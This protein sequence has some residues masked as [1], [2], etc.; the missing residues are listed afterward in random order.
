MVLCFGWE[1]TETYKVNI[2]I[3]LRINRG[4]YMYMASVNW[5]TIALDI[6]KIFRPMFISPLHYTL[7]FF[8]PPF[9]SASLLLSSSS[10]QPL[11]LPPLLFGATIDKSTQLPQLHWLACS[12]PSLNHRCCT[13]PLHYPPCSTPTLAP[14]LP[15]LLHH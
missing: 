13:V 9:S 7:S 3:K 6:F 2:G 14:L 10:P 11:S 5:R 8:C 12:T 15:A 1:R 4:V